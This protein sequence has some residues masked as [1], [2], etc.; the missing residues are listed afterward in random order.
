[1]TC[2]VIPQSQQLRYP[3][4]LQPDRWF[5]LLPESLQTL[6]QQTAWQR[7]CGYLHH[8]TEVVSVVPVAPGLC[9]LSGRFWPCRG[10]T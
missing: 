10:G 5:L 9:A 6:S 3:P 1:M 7:G 2:H 4:P 8:A